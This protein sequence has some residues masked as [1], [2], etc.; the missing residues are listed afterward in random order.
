[1]HQLQSLPYYFGWALGVIPGLAFFA[2]IKFNAGEPWSLSNLLAGCA[3]IG[4]A[5]SMFVLLTDWEAVVGLLQSA[6]KI[7]EAEHQVSKSSSALWLVVIPTVFGGVGVNVVSAWLQSR[8]PSQ[9]T[10]RFGI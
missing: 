1:M 3:L 7:T 6:G 5:I 9:P 4:T 2:C 10:S 8:R